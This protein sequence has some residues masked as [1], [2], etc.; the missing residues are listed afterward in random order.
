MDL[1]F[2]VLFSWLFTMGFMSMIED[3]YDEVKWW[4]IVLAALLSPML[5]P[6]LLGMFVSVG[7]TS[8]RAIDQLKKMK[9]E[10]IINVVL[11]KR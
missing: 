6:L 3:S 1:W 4:H 2:Y 5:F 7:C 8:V 10:G 11:N 9:D